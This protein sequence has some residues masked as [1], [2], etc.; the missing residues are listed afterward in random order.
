[1]AELFRQTPKPR[2]LSWGIGAKGE[3]VDCVDVISCRTNALLTREL[4]LPSFRF[5]D[6]PERVALDSFGAL[7]YRLE[8]YD[9]YYVDAGLE[10]E[11]LQ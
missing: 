7:V 3:R 11:T 8:H 4:S 5:L 1:M 9:F 6:V 2:Q 10:W